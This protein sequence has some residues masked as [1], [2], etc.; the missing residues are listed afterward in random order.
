MSD[1][2]RPPPRLRLGPPNLGAVGAASGVPTFEVPEAVTTRVIAPFPLRLQPLSDI[3]R[4]RKSLAN[5]GKRIRPVYESLAPPR[6]D[7]MFESKI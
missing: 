6:F 5:H 2:E 7:I 3:G 1:P 4:G